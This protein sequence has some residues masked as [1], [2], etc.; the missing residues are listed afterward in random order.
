MVN[1]FNN[2][3]RNSTVQLNTQNHANKHKMHTLCMLVCLTNWLSLRIMHGRIKNKNTKSKPHKKK[4]FDFL[5]FSFVFYIFI[6]RV[7][8]EMHCIWIRF[9]VNV[10]ILR[11][12]VFIAHII[13]PI[14]LCLDTCIHIYSLDGPVDYDNA[15]RTSHKIMFACRMKC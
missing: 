5:S 11:P 6:Q 4:L 12:H 10:N 7:C 15:S 1:I 14:E 9:Y 8:W 13:W 3:K 2:Q